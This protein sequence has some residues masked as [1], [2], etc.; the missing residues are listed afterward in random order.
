MTDFSRS[1]LTKWG[2]RFFE[3]RTQSDIEDSED[4]EGAILSEDEEDLIK[5]VESEEDLEYVG[6]GGNRVCFSIPHTDEVVIF[7][8]WGPENNTLHNGR[9]CNLNEVEIWTSLVSA[10]KQSEYRFLPI[11]DYQDEGWWVIKPE[12]TPVS[13][14]TQEV[15]DEWEDTGKSEL[16][17]NVF[18]F[19][20]HVNMMDL[21]MANA[22]LWDGE[23]VW[24]D[25][26]TKPQA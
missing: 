19:S 3:A 11:R 18:G 10:G 6:F 24:F 7:P 8:R 12:I 14:D 17:D 5:D 1:T 20:D 4:V 22:C 21:T 13:E 26:G 23:F 15:I 9:E 16:W 25:Y 2:N